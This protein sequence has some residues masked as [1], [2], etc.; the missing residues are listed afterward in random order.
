MLFEVVSKLGRR[1]RVTKRYWNYIVS[2]KHPSVRGLERFAMEALRNPVEV[3]RSA[4]DPAV[5]TYYGL[6]G[7]KYICV[8]AKHLNSEGYV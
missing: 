3:R 1:I 4:R 8:V 7:D 2:V 6:A 5:F